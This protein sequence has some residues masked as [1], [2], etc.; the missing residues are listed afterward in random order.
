MNSYKMFFTLY[1]EKMELSLQ[2]I[3]K[4]LQYFKR[5]LEILTQQKGYETEIDFIQTKEIPHYLY[6]KE[7][8]NKVL[9]K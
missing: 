8:F 7:R 9:Q 2:V 1:K 3:E 5:E 4:Q 6:V